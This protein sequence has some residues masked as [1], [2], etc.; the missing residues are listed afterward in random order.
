MQSLTPSESLYAGFRY[1]WDGG[2][3]PAGASP[4]ETVVA[5]ILGPGG[6]ARIFADGHI[7][8]K[9]QER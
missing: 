8:W 4:A 9:N 3:L 2:A 6:S 7:A 1:L 5:E